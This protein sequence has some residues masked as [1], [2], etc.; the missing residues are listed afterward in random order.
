MIVTPEAELGVGFGHQP[1]N[2]TRPPNKGVADLKG[3]ERVPR[4]IRHMWA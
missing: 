3:A 1:R 4:S 2:G